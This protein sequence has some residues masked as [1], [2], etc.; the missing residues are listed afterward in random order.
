M[1]QVSFSIKAGRNDILKVKFISHPP[2]TKVF[3]AAATQL[4]KAEGIWIE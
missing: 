2:G 4:K 3:F 1:H